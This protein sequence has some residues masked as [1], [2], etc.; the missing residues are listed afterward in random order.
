MYT[1]WQFYT[2]NI[3]NVFLSLVIIKS[4]TGFNNGLDE[5]QFDLYNFRCKMLALPSFALHSHSLT[6]LYACTVL[7]ARMVGSPLHLSREYVF[8]SNSWGDPRGVSLAREDFSL[9]N[10]LCPGIIAPIDT[11]WST[12]TDA[13]SSACQL[14]VPTITIPGRSFRS[15][16]TEKLSISSKKSVPLMHCQTSA[17]PL[18]TGDRLLGNINAELRTFVADGGEMRQNPVFVFVGNIKINTVKT[19]FLHL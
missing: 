4:C 7:R 15:G 17:P 16:S 2:F 11:L 3:F 14:Y 12:M 8:L 19:A 13:I 6:A 9:G 1:F 18:P 10:Y 5:H